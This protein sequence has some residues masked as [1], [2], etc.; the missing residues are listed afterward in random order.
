[1]WRIRRLRLAPGQDYITRI[2][3]VLF[4]EDQEQGYRIWTF[5]R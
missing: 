5:V 4:N 3:Q 2:S 1:M